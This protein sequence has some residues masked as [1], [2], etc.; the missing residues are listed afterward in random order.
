MEYLIKQQIN[1]KFTYLLMRLIK[2]VT[3]I[4]MFGVKVITESSRIYFNFESVKH[5]LLLLSINLM[6]KNTYLHMYIVL[7]RHSCNFG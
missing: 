1:F 7:K 4:S 5:D 2:H 6:D 3:S